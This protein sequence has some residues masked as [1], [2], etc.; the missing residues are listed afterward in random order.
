M[1]SWRDKAKPFISD[2]RPIV[3]IEPPPVALTSGTTQLTG[4][5]VSRVPS[6]SKPLAGSELTSVWQARYDKDSDFRNKADQIAKTYGFAD[7]RDPKVHTSGGAQLGPKD[8]W[9]E[10]LEMYK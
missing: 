1:I 5:S 3:I 9:Y 2:S 8:W 6:V 4:L 7:G 10:I